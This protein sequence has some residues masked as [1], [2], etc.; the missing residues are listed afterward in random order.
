MIERLQA[1]VTE[2]YLT[3]YSVEVVQLK[4]PDYQKSFLPRRLT[5]NGLMLFVVFSLK[6]LKEGQNETFLV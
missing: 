5:L 6:E 3:T 4:E 1:I 2:T